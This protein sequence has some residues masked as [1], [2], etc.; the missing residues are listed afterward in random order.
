MG[1]GR[2]A[3]PAGREMRAAECLRPPMLSKGTKTPPTPTAAATALTPRAACSFHLHFTL[4]RADF[5][6]RPLPCSSKAIIRM[7]FCAGFCLKNS[8]NLTEMFPMT[9][10]DL[11]ATIQPTAF[12]EWIRS[13]STPH[14]LAAYHGMLTPLELDAPAAESAA[15]ATAAACHDLGWL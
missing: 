11:A 15:L 6:L 7:R 9:Q 1:L 3:E 14:K 5:P 10:T 13:A 8:S 4:V 2:K 12:A